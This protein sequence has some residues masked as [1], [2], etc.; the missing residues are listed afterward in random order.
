MNEYNQIK[1]EALFLHEEENTRS[2]ECPYCPPEDKEKGSLSVTRKAEGLVFHCYR[3]KCGEKG[4]IPTSPNTT[5]KRPR[6]VKKI[7]N[8]FNHTLS[9]LTDE[10]YRQLILNYN[11]TV[12]EIEI[13][14]IRWVE[15]IKRIAVPLFDKNYL[16]WGWEAKLI[17]GLEPPWAKR[18]RWIKSITYPTKEGVNRLYYPKLSKEYIEERP[19]MIEDTVVVV[20]DVFSAMRVMRYRD[21]VALLGSSLNIAQVLELMEGYP[22]VILALDNDATDKAIKIAKE[23]SGYFKNFEVKQLEKDPKNMT[24]DE[25][26]R[27]FLLV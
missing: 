7:V 3:A 4:F 14:G 10:Q 26:E 6:K 5:E 13:S 18:G 17:K 2:I 8:Q 12:D 22:N 15:D 9:N 20:E 16:Q 11:L 27:E 25:L 23:Y 24:E 19:S 21:S 1:M